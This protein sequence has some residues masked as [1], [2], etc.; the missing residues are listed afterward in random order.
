MSSRSYYWFLLVLA[1]CSEPT[2]SGTDADHTPVD[3]SHDAAPLDAAPLDAAPLDAAPLDAEPPSCD[4]DTIAP[5]DCVG[6]AIGSRRCLHDGSAYDAC[7]C[8]MPALALWVTPGASDGD[9][10]EAR[11][12]G[13]LDAARDALRERITAGL[14][15]GE[16]VV[17]LRGGSYERTSTFAL[18]PEDSGTEASPITWRALPG[19]T[20]RIRGGRHLDAGCFSPVPSG[21]A[22]ESRLDPTARVRIRQCDLRAQGIDDFGALAPRQSHGPSASSSALELFIDDEPMWLARW[23]DVD[24]SDPPPDLSGETLTIYGAT[25]PDI[26]GRYTRSGTE[27]GAPVFTRDALVLGQRYNLYRHTPSDRAYTA[28]FLT[29]ASSGYPPAPD[30]F[31]YR[32][33]AALGPMLPAQGGTGTLSFRPLDAINHGFVDSVQVL[34]ATTF[35]YA[36]D[37]PSRW[38]QADDVWVHGLLQ[39]AW[40]DSHMPANFDTDAR[41]VTLGQEPTFGIAD[42]RPYYVYNLIEEL[43][44]PGEYYLDRATGVLYLDPQSPL[45]G[46]DIV[47]SMLSEPVVRMNMVSHVTLRDVIIEAGRG[48]QVEIRGG[49][50]LRLEGLEVRN[51]GVN[52]IVIRDGATRVTVSRAHV[53]G[54]GNTGISIHGG[55]RPSLTRADIFVENSEI[56]DVG[57]FVWMYQ[58]GVIAR[59]VGITVRQCHLHHMPH[60]AIYWDGNEHLFERNDIEYVVQRSSDAGAIYAGR[61]W[62]ARGNV[63]RHN[64]IRHISTPV[65]G[66]GAH[67]I[68]LDDVLSGVLV[69]GNVL[70]DIS[71]HAVLHG[72]GR[73]NTI[74]FNVFARCGT[75]LA[76][77]ARGETAITNMDDGWNLLE[78]LRANGYQDEPWASRYPACAAIPDD[79]GVISAPGSRWRDPEGTIFQGNL[80]WQLDRFLIELDNATSYFASIA[81]NVEDADPRFVDEEGEDFMLSA[82][83]PAFAIPGF[84]TIPFDRIGIAP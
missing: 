30:P 35:T 14:P 15:A 48:N 7:E 71:H 27:D 51:G 32:Y 37:R 50:E 80:G 76:T 75:G 4:P 3:A 20:V 52:G 36:G 33:N 60:S 22:I 49:S 11:P 6:G 16:V 25:T 70:Y 84:S 42:T 13:T 46:A 69:E 5:C 23:P 59:G 67:G 9:G 56:H 40:A 62:G 68:Y 79:W 28:W 77:D 24:A 82:D 65:E 1:A 19:E 31:W 17:W 58:A 53:H 55:H 21:A 74:R 57:R 41:T 29:T 54:H 45:A 18:G 10:T 39:W 64:L 47:V 43:T 73:D 12:F 83:S 2:P 26:S 34:D 81:D 78:K 38:S 8:V 72:G 61:D 63:I 44:Q 66:S